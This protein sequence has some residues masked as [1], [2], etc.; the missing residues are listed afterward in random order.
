[1]LW[2]LFIAQ[3]ATPVD[4]ARATRC[5]WRPVCRVY[6]HELGLDVEGQE[7]PTLAGPVTR[8]AVSFSPLKR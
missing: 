4:W 7:I 5:A 8:L 2:D 6:G 1:M 3:G